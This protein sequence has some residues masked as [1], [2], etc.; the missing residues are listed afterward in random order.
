MTAFLKISAHG[1]PIFND[2]PVQFFNSYT[3]YVFGGHNL[4][5]PTDPGAYF[6]PFCLYPGE[7]Q[8]SGHI[9]VSRAREFFLAYKGQPL[10]GGQTISATNTAELRIVA[11]C[12]NFLLISDGNASLRYS[13]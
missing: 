5:S 11:T 7:Y 2:L 10:S 8:P 13:T 1:I 9:N 3:P 6:V 12:I 4:N